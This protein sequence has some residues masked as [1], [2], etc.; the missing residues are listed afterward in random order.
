ME[1]ALADECGGLRGWYFAAVVLRHVGGA[2]PAG[3]RNCTARYRRSGRSTPGCNRCICGTSFACT[4]ISSSGTGDGRRS[5]RRV[6]AVSGSAIRLSRRTGSRSSASCARPR[7]RVHADR[8]DGLL[9]GDD[10]VALGIDCRAREAHR[11]CDPSPLTADGPPA[12]EGMCRRAGHSA[13]AISSDA[14]Q[15]VRV[16]RPEL[17]VDVEGRPTLDDEAERLE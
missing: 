5:A 10:R 1:S 4:L 7:L 16:S 6:Q 15:S 12:Q 3:R 17:G 13:P 2:G 8:V 11:A 14:T 9:V